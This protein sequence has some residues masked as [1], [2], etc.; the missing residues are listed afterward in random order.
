MEQTFFRV[1]FASNGDT[2]TIPETI[3]TDG[4]VNWPQGWSL[5]YEK[6]MDADANAKAVER[7][8]MNFMFNAVT[9]ALRQYQSAAFPEFIT[10]ADNNGSAFPYSAGTVVRY[11][12]TTSVSF[13]NYVSLVDNNTA[14]P[15]HRARTQQNGRSSFFQKQVKLKPKTEKA[16]Q[17]LLPRVV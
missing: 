7:E 2:S 12:A 15:R 13:R 11:R 17:Q 10:A 3:T 16:E 6:D 14:T 9:V 1:P 5:D 4:S 8:V